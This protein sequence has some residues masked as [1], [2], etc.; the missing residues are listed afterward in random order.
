MLDKIVACCFLKLEFKDRD[1]LLLH[2][3]DFSFGEFLTA[4]FIVDCV[5]F[6]RVDLLVLGGEKHRGNTNKMKVGDL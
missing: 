3:D 1:Y 5:N 6:E 2:I 4:D